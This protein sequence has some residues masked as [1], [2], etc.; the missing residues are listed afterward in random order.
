MGRRQGIPSE[1]GVKGERKARENSRTKQDGPENEQQGRDDW[2]RTRSEVDE[3]KRE[4]RGPNVI[5][6][7]SKGLQRS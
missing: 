2:L 5:E 4:L 3:G 6:C 1:G 7:V